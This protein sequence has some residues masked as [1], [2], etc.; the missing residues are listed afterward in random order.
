MSTRRP[1]SVH[2]SSARG[3]PALLSTLALLLVVSCR[4]DEGPAAECRH[5]EDCTDPA[6]ACV[7]GACAAKIR[8]YP[9]VAAEIAPPSDSRFASTE[10]NAVSLSWETSLSASL[11]VNVA[12]TLQA[13]AEGDVFTS[14]GHVVLSRPSLITGKAPLSTAAEL[15]GGTVSF[16]LP[17]SALGSEATF[18]L[19]PATTPATQPPLSR[20]VTL[21]PQISVALPRREDLSALT[22]TLLSALGDP[23]PSYL[24]RGIPL[25]GSA[26]A[27]PLTSA[28]L[29]GAD[30]AF[31]L[32]ADPA[33]Q[34]ASGASSIRLEFWD[35][36]EN[37]MSP[38]LYT[39]AVTATGSNGQYGKN[40]WRLA[41]YPAPTKLRFRV[42]GGE[43]LSTS[44]KDATMRFRTKLASAGSGEAIY[45]QEGKTDDQGQVEVSLVPG[46]LAEARLYDLAIVPPPDSPFD[47]KCLN[48]FPVTAPSSNGEVPVA[49][50]VHLDRKWQ[51]SGRVL[52]ADG[53]TVSNA[54]V[55]ATRVAS[56]A[57]HSCLV[58]LVADTTSDNTDATGAYALLLPGGTYRLEV[59]APSG[60]PRPRL[61]ATAAGDPVAM[62][63]D[64][65]RDFQLPRGVVA[66]GTA[67]GPDGEPVANADLRFYRVPCPSACSGTSAP[68]LLGVSRSDGAGAFRVVVPAP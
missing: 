1:R 38:R 7:A 33:T 43:S 47:G 44:I 53:K 66:R 40:Q 56:D 35:G 45:S 14:Q 57:A 51:L 68:E 46:T 52:D 22:G 55:T 6:L 25:D 64:L 65:G 12:L 21:A 58:G 10:V 31:T 16:A 9:T 67:T 61:T 59:D 20:T 23:A 62:S 2:G 34:Q 32:L 30:G 27:T 29:T 37:A 4:R 3:V 19:L 36:R 8:D 60:S 50:T 5:D 49:S 15:A 13:N 26:A 11:K 41:A 24:V 48:A 54:T 63:A 17:T 42:S 39:D 18:T 28:A